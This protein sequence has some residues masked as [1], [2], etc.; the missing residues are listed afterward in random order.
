[1]S[2]TTHYDRLGIPFSAPIELIK[3]AYREKA[4]EYH[5][6]RHPPDR[7]DWARQQFERIEKAYEVLSD[8]RERALYDRELMEKRSV[9][10]AKD[11]F[12]HF[13]REFLSKHGND[14]QEL[15]YHEKMVMDSYEE[16]WLEEM[17]GGT[18]HDR[19]TFRKHLNFGKMQLAQSNRDEAHREFIRAD[20]TC[21]RN[22]L[23][24]FYVGYCMELN[25]NYEDALKRYEFAVDIGLS[26]PR[27]YVNKCLS[28]RERMV[29]LYDIVNQRTLAKKQRRLIDQ[30][31][32]ARYGFEQF[33][34][35]DS[36]LSRSDTRSW[37]RK[38]F[39]WL[40]SRN[41]V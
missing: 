32:D 30:L 3:K 16:D 38:L 31:R 9:P 7:R 28:I 6:D 1:M 19:H 12:W 15:T 2:I 4:K 13:W 22:I 5:P 26:R 24:K 35:A 25:G 37:T 18:T 23:S 21:R 17:H 29:E 40:V 36:G 10:I 20:T 34:E 11:D 41:S 14:Q 8:P 33:L 39:G 27:E